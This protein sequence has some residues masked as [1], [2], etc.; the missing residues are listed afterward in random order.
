M[1]FAA[2]TMDRRSLFL[3]H[4]SGYQELRDPEA[5]QARAVVDEADAAPARA[6][7]DAELEWV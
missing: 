1:F 5:E 2:H 6:V 7:R 4:L 3:I